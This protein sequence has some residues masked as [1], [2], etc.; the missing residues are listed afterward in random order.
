VVALLLLDDAERDQGVDVERV[1]GQ[2]G[3]QVGLGGGELEVLGRERRAVDQRRGEPGVALD[4]LVVPHARLLEEALLLQDQA[5]QVQEAR[6]V[7]GAVEAAAHDELGDG[8]LLHGEVG[9]GKGDVGRRKAL[10]DADQVAQHLVAFVPV[11][12]RDVGE[13]ERVAGF[14]EEGVADLDG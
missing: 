11:A 4:G 1:A 10:V 2:G 14:A 5:H 3:G 12:A 7:L 9:G 6:V 8:V 13:R